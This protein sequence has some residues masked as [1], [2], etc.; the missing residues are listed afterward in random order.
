MFDFEAAIFDLDGTIADSNYVWKKVDADFFGKRGFEVPKDYWEK[1]NSLS[2][3]EAAVFTK[4]EYGFPETIDEIKEEWCSMAVE[5]YSFYVKPKKYA[6]KYIRHIKKNGVKTALCTASPK[7][8]YEPFLKNN[9]MFSYFDA[10]VSGTEVKR[11]KGFPDI[12]LL[13]A[14]RL[15]VLPEKCV[16]FEDILSAVLGAK[17]AGMKTFGVYDQASSADIK[18]IMEKA[19]GFINDFSEIM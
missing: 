15:D 13:A 2:F 1:I 3:N 4:N 5:E 18:K 12:Y 19:D 9:G 7:E 10:F 8:L 11:G 16:V 14:K 6:E 17:S